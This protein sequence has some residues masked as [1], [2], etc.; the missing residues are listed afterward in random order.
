MQI[1][2][3]GQPLYPYT[4]SHPL[5]SSPVHSQV[6]CK[7]SVPLMD[8]P[9]VSDDV[10]LCWFKNVVLIFFFLMLTRLSSIIYIIN[11][12]VDLCKITAGSSNEHLNC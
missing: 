7:W 8:R 10:F 11:P 9:G 12:N 5:H 4:P 2:S 1:M 6:A 3:S